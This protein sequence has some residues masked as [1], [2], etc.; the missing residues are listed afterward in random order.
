M[1]PHSME[2]FKEIL[3]QMTLMRDIKDIGRPSH[4]IFKQMVAGKSIS[5]QWD[6]L[7]SGPWLSSKQ[8][9]AR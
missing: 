5:V 3:F 4:Q 1:S 9:H 2:G 8:C 7:P 6:L